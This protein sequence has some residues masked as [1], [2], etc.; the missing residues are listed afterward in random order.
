[1]IGD[2]DIGSSSSE[3][4]DQTEWT[5]EDEKD[6]LRTLGALKTHDPNIYENDLNFFGQK[7]RYRPEQTA[8][9]N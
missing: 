4:E 7:D 6:F 1:M 3:S 2:N 5:A 9:L 8:I